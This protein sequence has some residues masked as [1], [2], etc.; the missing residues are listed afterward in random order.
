MQRAWYAGSVVGKHGAGG[1]N[2]RV[3]DWGGRVVGIK[4]RGG[5]TGRVNVEKRRDGRG[6]REG[7]GEGRR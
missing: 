6:G 3:L 4:M 5:T 7:A 1:G 2:A